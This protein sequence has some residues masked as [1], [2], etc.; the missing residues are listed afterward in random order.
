[1]ECLAG[2]GSTTPPPL[3]IGEMSTKIVS[4]TLTRRLGSLCLLGRLSVR[5]VAGGP[6]P[7][8]A[9]FELCP[10]LAS[11][12]PH[13]SLCHPPGGTVSQHLGTEGFLVEGAGGGETVHGP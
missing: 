11:L 7:T 2:G 1:M 8:T 9:F 5:Q 3:L 12:C 4:L 13:P 10:P 6:R